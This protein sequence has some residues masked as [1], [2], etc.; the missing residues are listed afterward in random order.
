MRQ[1]PWMV[2]CALACSVAGAAGADVVGYWHCNGFDPA[3][4]TVLTANVGSGVLDVTDFG[5][6]ATAFGGTD[7]NA[8]AGVI[9]GDSV[10]LT[11]SSHNGAF[12]QINL[13]TAGWQDLSLSFAAR[14]SAT[15]FANDTV[16]ALIG[17]NWTN[18]ATFT[19]S[20][21]AWSLV[22][23][24][25]SSFNALENGTASLRLLL[26]G[27]TSGSGTIRFDNL[28]I[29]G[30]TAV[31]AP[32]AIALLGGAGLVGARGRRRR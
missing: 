30:S 32:G 12:A 19:A 5:T 15:G 29:T 9:A 3:V 4:S 24:D 28:T 20:S 23:I 21:T 11:G 13:S 31:P 25:L 8:M 27:A 26:D 6:G 22:T 16:Q 10:G 2:S 7:V 18:V 17:G 1:L 14:R